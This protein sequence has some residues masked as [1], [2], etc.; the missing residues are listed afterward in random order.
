MSFVKINETLT[1]ALNNK[2]KLEDIPIY[3]KYVIELKKDDNSIEIVKCLIVGYIY[4]NVDEKT[5]NEDYF[6][7]LIKVFDK[8]TVLGFLKEKNIYEMDLR[9]TPLYGNRK[10]LVTYL[11]IQ[12]SINNDLTK[13]NDIFIK[14]ECYPGKIRMSM[15]PRKNVATFN[16]SHALLLALKD[17]EIYKNNDIELV[18]HFFKNQ[19][20][21]PQ[22]IQYV[23]TLEC[24]SPHKSI[25]CYS[26]EF[27]EDSSEEFHINTNN[28]NA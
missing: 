28:I 10:M 14:D 4:E 3:D 23:E 19:M 17:S 18:K 27:K 2:I 11:Y 26:K 24:I 5:M 20:S 25:L 12:E 15:N 9:S 13:E 16:I 6:N 22:D 8:Y 21:L 7:E 1:K